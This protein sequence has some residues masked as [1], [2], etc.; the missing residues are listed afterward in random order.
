[1]DGKFYSYIWGNEE[2]WLNQRIC[3]FENKQPKRKVFILYTIKP[4]LNH[5]EQTQLATTIIHIGKKDYD[6][7][8]ILLPDEDILNKFY[9]ITAPIIEQ[10]VNDHL[11][12]KHLVNLRDTLLPKL[13]SG[14]INVSNIDL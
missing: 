10:I 6:S 8:K 4:L 2:A 3:I 9:E 1:M 14:K 12:N 11:E 5:I 7:F 13:M